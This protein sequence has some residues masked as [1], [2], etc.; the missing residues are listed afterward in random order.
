MERTQ[1]P[2]DHQAR[3]FIEAM[4]ARAKTELNGVYSPTIEVTPALAR[5]LLARNTSNRNPSEADVRETTAV[6]LAGEYAITGEAI[7][8]ASDGTLSNGQRRCE[9]VK[10]AGMSIIST[11]SFG[12]APET[13]IETDQT[14]PH[15]LAHR[16]QRLEVS[17]STDVATVVTDLYLYFYKGYVDRK[18]GTKKNWRASVKMFKDDDAV[19]LTALSAVRE[20]AVKLGLK[21]PPVGLCRV[22]A[23]TL[24]VT[25]KLNSAQA[26]T[27][28]EAVMSGA[29]LN[30]GD[31]AL[32][33]R[34]T[35]SM[36]RGL[37]GHEQFELY[38]RAWNAYRE[39]RQLKQLQARNDKYNFPKAI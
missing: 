31:P 19:A 22:F 37:K 7:I 13:A 35:L 25:G 11:V 17:N 23:G 33:L 20:T 4:L 30:T 3:N 1:L 8:V 15:T 18:E 6:I 28:L 32:T 5:E 2:E 29:S 9:A 10:R 36:R 26:K 27:F 16:F 38:V 34:D 21:K 14:R 39:G 12:P 24:V